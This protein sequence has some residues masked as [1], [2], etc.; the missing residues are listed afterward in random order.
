MAE[1]VKSPPPSPII[2]DSCSFCGQLGFLVRSQGLCAHL[3][4]LYISSRGVRHDDGGHFWFQK[5]SGLSWTLTKTI[6]VSCAHGDGVAS[7]DDST[8]GEESSSNCQG[9]TWQGSDFLDRMASPSPEARAALA[10]HRMRG[11][12]S[13]SPASARARP[14]A[15]L[16][17]IRGGAWKHRLPGA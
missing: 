8:P 17:Q 13:A 14:A 10:G 2:L 11:P 15:Q 5:D 12:A 1:G 9:D 6:P 7:T 16:L 4:D 3:Q